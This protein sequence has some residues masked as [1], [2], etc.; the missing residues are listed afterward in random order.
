MSLASS[1]YNYKMRLF[2]CILKK[3][4]PK[5]FSHCQKS[6]TTHAHPPNDLQLFLRR[7]QDASCYI[8][9][10]GQAPTLI[11]PFR[12][13]CHSTS[14]AHYLPDIYKRRTYLSSATY[15]CCSQPYLRSPQSSRLVSQQR[16]AKT[17]LNSPKISTYSL[18]IK[19]SQSIQAHCSKREAQQYL[20]KEKSEVGYLLGSEFKWVKTCL[21]RW[22][23]T[24]IGQS[25]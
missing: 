24:G 12:S 9:T 13:L 1:A 2:F 19:Q 22:G 3:I 23:L 7:S 17:V 8:C 21:L 15:C 18:L 10:E 16:Q 20:R 4:A 11:L 5:S 6:A 14:T 25:L